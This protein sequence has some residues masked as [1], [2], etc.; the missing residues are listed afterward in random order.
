MK[1]LA[2]STL[3]ATS[4]FGVATAQQKPVIEVYESPLCGCCSQWVTHLEKNGFTTRVIES[5]DLDALKTKLGVPERVRSCHTGV[6]DGY[7]IEGHVPASD[8]EDLLNEKNDE[9]IGLAVPGM[10]LGA[11]GMEA[12]ISE[13]YDVLAFNKKGETGVFAKYRP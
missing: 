10:P 11:P 9:V 5:D 13:A 3:V 7:A 12:E 2:A 8:I 4:I 1:L 6:V